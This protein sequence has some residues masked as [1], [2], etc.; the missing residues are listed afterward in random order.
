MRTNDCPATDFNI[1][2]PQ[3]GGWMNENGGDK[4]KRCRI[5]I[6]RSTH[7]AIADGDDILSVRREF[8]KHLISAEERTAFPEQFGLV[9]VIV[10]KAEELKLVLLSG[11][12]VD[13]LHDVMDFA[14]ETASANY[15]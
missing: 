7:P 12:I 6:D 3:S 13:R 5:E 11:G 15:H 2:T 10:D 1:V 8:V 4:P 9:N 14:P